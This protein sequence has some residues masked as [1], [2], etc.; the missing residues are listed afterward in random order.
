MGAEDSWAADTVALGERKSEREPAR[1][2][3]PR[4]RAPKRKRSAPASRVVVT[5]AAAL[6]VVAALAAILGSDSGSPKAPIRDV[7]DPAPRVVV[8]QPTRMRR[9]EPRRI[10]KPHFRH[11]AKGQLEG[12]REPKASA[13]TPELDEPEP[14]AEAAPEPI[15]E[16]VPEPEPVPEA[17]PAPPASPAP[18][19]PATEFGL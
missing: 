14:I 18:I 4:R 16:P 19:P 11:R 3:P 9:R 12:K 17:E 1:P 6:V 10:A 2:E 15:A 8:K 5:C 13:A 7:A